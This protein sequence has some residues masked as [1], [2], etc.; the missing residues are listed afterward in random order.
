MEHCN[1]CNNQVEDPIRLDNHCNLPYCKD[2]LIKL[3]N[4]LWDGSRF[5]TTEERICDRCG[6]EFRIFFEVHH[7]GELEY[8]CT[9]C[10][11]CL[12]YNRKLIQNLKNR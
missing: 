11:P 1:G 6:K 4:T 9:F 2:C 8:D 10:G 12:E 3:E 7:K 5:E